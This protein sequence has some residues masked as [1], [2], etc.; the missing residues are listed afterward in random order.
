MHPDPHVHAVRASAAPLE[1]VPVDA[2][3]VCLICDSLVAQRR[4]EPTGITG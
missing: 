2:A 4:L 3:H 1:G